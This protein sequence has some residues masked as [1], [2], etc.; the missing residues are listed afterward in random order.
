MTVD[1]LYMK[2]TTI[3]EIRDWQSFGIVVL[4]KQKQTTTKAF[5][6]P[7]E[8]SDY[9]NLKVIPETTKFYGQTVD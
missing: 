1:C 6:C 4:P 9:L 3:K 8:D 2:L 5:A 7:R